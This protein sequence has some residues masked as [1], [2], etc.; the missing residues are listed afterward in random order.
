MK[1]ARS[2]LLP[3]AHAAFESEI[4][5]GFTMIEILTVIG[6]IAIL[7]AMV[8]VGFNVLGDSQGR[9][10]RVAM[11]TA[12]NMQ[13]EYANATPLVGGLKTFQVVSNWSDTDIL[14]PS[15]PTICIFEP[16]VAAMDKFLKVPANKSAME[17]VDATNVVSFS[18]LIAA[19]SSVNTYGA[20][21][22]LTKPLLLDGWQKPLLFVGSGGLRNLTSE[23]SGSPAARA[24]VKAPDGQPFWVSAG[25]DGNF[26]THDDN[27]YSFE[28]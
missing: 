8:A 9:R 24:D 4:H 16:T 1:T 17:K 25:P 11:E 5:R 18:V 27:V 21:K 19:G 2:H 12:M 7:L 10:T 26:Q 6:I 28:N 22:E 14:T 15:N 13:Q 20:E 23:V 3:R